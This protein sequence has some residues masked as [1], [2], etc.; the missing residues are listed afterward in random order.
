[1]KQINLTQREDKHIHHTHKMIP[2]I[3]K[4]LN[5]LMA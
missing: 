1:M 5:R 3:Q 4:N 2:K